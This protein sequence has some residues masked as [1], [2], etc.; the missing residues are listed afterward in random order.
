VLV[1]IVF[2]RSCNWGLP[3]M[4]AVAF[5]PHCPIRRVFG[6]G[7]LPLPFNIAGGRKRVVGL[8][9]WPSFFARG[10][11]AGV[12][13]WARMGRLRRMSRIWGGLDEKFAL[14]GN[15]DPLGPES[16][17]SSVT[18]DHSLPVGAGNYSSRGASVSLSRTF[19]RL[20]VF[21]SGSD[22]P[23]RFP[24]ELIELGSIFISRRMLHLDP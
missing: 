20:T 22:S 2:R 9:V 13:G 5:F 14:E 10:G 18:A 24:C 21:G 15:C 23:S 17:S 7:P 1:L 16:I 4:R 6:A 8:V 12:W 11:W 3:Q 19:K